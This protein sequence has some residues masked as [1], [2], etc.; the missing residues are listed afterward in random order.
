MQKN[1]EKECEEVRPNDPQIKHG[2][3]SSEI[4]AEEATSNVV[5]QVDSESTGFCGQFWSCC[6]SGPPAMSREV[7][8]TYIIMCT[9]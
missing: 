1:Q 4:Q 3:S 9:S 8:G 5:E 2:E 6:G 7:E